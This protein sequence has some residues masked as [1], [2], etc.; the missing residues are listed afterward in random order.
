MYALRGICHGRVSVCLCVRLSVTS[1]SST[2]IA[3]HRN[4]QTTPHDSPGTSVFWC[5]KCFRNSNVVIPN[6]AP[7]A[8]GVR[9]SQR[10]LTN[11]WLYLENGTRPDETVFVCMCVCCCIFFCSLCYCI[12]HVH[13]VRFYNK[14]NKKWSWTPF[15]SRSILA[16]PIWRRKWGAEYRPVWRGT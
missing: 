2:K 11:Y 15:K 3:E 5:Q 12:A 14:Q 10:T 6:G 16:F 8:G 7:N 1:R 9:Q 4:T 13:R